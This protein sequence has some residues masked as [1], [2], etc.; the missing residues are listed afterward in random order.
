[1][2]RII[3]STVRGFSESILSLTTTEKKK[4]IGVR[5]S[6]CGGHSTGLRRP[7]H[8]WI[9]VHQQTDALLRHSVEELR[10]VERRSRHSHAV[11][12]IVVKQCPSACQDTGRV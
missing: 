7:I 9:I 4:S 8:L 1:M 5:S 12:V 2:Q 11:T 3:S 6:D 10:L